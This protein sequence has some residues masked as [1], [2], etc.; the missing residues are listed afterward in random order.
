[1]MK[2]FRFPKIQVSGFLLPNFRSI[3][4]AL[5]SVTLFSC[6]LFTSFSCVHALSPEANGDNSLQIVIE[7]SENNEKTSAEELASPNSQIQTNPYPDL[8]DDQVFPFA[9]GLDSY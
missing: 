3:G 5:L 1:M 8:G 2:K 4:F 9:A 7:P 6:A